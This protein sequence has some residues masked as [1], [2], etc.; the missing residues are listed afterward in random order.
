MTMKILKITLLVLIVPYI[1]MDTV[2]G[3]DLTCKAGEEVIL[4]PTLRESGQCNNNNKITT[5]KE[6][7][8][9]NFSTP[10]NI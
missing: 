1:M 10:Y 6:R 7:K 8:E 2:S 3:A 4:A 9:A 5:K